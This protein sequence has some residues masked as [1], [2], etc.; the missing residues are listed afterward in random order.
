MA[1]LRPQV[2][3]LAVGAASRS[4]N[5]QISLDDAMPVINRQLDNPN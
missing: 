5:R 2:A 4:S 1:A 3:E